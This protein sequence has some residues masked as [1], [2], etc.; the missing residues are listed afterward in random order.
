MTRSAAPPRT[1][2]EGFEPGAMVTRLA[3]DDAGARFAPSTY[4]AE[5][6]TVEAVFSS[7]AR[8]RRWGI[9]EELAISP[10]A[11][12]LGRVTLGQV[13][14]LDSHNQW[15]VD[16]I[17]GTVTSARIEND[18]LVGSFRFGEGPRA[19]EI[20]A[21]V[22]TGDIVGISCGYRV[23]NWMLAAVEDG[24]EIWRAERWELLEV[25]LVAVPADPAAMVRSGS[26]ISQSNEV[27]D[28]RRNIPAAP[29]TAPANP[30]APGAAPEASP[31]TRSV[32]PTAP[33]APP[34]PQPVPPAADANAVRAAERERVQE[35]MTI[36]RQHNLDDAIVR[37]AVDDGTSLDAFRRAALDTLAQ[38]AD[39]TRV[40]GI[41]MGAS[42]DDPERVRAVLSEALVARMAESTG[43]RPQPSEQA[44]AYM[45]HSLV[46][47]AAVSL[48]R[49]A[50]P[51]TTRERVEVLERAFHSTSDFPIIFSG[52][53][54]VRLEAAYQAAMPVYRRIARRA[55]F[56]DFRPHDVLR[57]GDFP[58]LQKV[59]EGGEIKFG[60]FGEKKET[61][62][63]APYGI[64]FALTRQM[65]V[66]DNLGDI[67]QILAGQGTTVALF[68][69]TTFFAMK[70]TVGPVLNEDAKAVFHAGHANLAAAGS[71]IDV[72]ALSNGRA[73]LRKQKRLDGTPMSLAPRLLLVG[74]DK[75]TEA[76]LIT[77]QVT[78]TQASN[79]NPFSGTLETVVSAMIAGKAWEL[80]AD[81]TFGANWQWGLLD[82]YA[83]PRLRV[84]EPFGVSGV[85]ISL[86]HDFGCGAIDF[87]FGY[88]N[89]GN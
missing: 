68:E 76:Q 77:A 79:V 67:D 70:G 39:E 47:L 72:T 2:P 37:A 88:R 81:P 71:A 23:T 48:G 30:S 74:P 40:S 3:T 5:A 58:M 26:G 9:V 89:P 18:A 78:P 50:M 56:M 86:E 32:A 14:V 45:G 51:R 46:E 87:R 83:A 28:M 34:A 53:L 10:E 66:N 75:E 16:D 19:R 22:A 11:I 49:R 13:R 17:L 63:V 31:E 55:D 7:G 80:Y 29:G 85:G 12:D 62:I 27:E 35:I 64:Q 82:G 57:V 41:S 84:D 65:L 1:S 52:A 20:E 38:R 44:R 33:V 4:D 61:I 8:V 59:T 36:G 21:R 15:S 43:A 25:S 60:T 6:R 42:A 54:N 69:E 24:V 73:A